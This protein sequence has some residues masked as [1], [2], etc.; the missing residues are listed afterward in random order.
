MKSIFPSRLV[1]LIAN[2]NLYFDLKHRDGLFEYMLAFARDLESD[3]E[4]QPLI[5]RFAGYLAGALQADSAIIFDCDHLRQELWVSHPFHVPPGYENLK[6][7]YMEGAAGLAAYN[8]KVV[9]V[10]NYGAFE[11]RENLYDQFKLFQHVIAEPVTRK[12]ET[13]YVLQVMR[14]DID[15]QFGVNDQQIMG[16][17]VAWF[18]LLVDQWHMTKRMALIIEYQN[19]L[20]RILE[21]SHFASGV[22]DLLNTI[23]DYCMPT[24]KSKRALIVCEEWSIARGISKDFQAQLTEN[25]ALNEDWRGVPVVIN[26]IHMAHNL[27]PDLEELFQQSNI[28]AFVLAPIMIEDQRIGYLLLANT[29]SCDWGEDLVTMVEITSKHLALEVRRVVTLTENEKRENLIWRMNTL[30]QKLSHVLTY[31]ESIQVV[32]N[33]AVELFSSNKIIMLIRTPQNKITNAFSYNIPDWSLQQIIDTEFKAL[34]DTFLSTD[35]P[36]LIPLVANSQMPLV[37]KPI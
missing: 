3:L 1:I 29:L 11:K 16:Q 33:I 10:N 6:L 21:T 5:D 18:G 37:L 4:F 28:Q 14:K 23:L 25:L 26:S 34:E 13:K 19:T 8:G 35:Y 27:H 15:N 7:N 2:T 12:N 22:P 31:E 24:L 30:G 36:F 20:S 9:V 17:M 32:G